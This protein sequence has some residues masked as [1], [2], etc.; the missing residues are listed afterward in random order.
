MFAI[1]FFKL[2]YVF[3]VF[4]MLGEN[5]TVP[6]R[7]LVCFQQ[8]RA[9]WVVL[10]DLQVPGTCELTNGCLGDGLP[11]PA[12]THRGAAGTLPSY[13]SSHHSHAVQSTHAAHTFL[14]LFFLFLTSFP[15]ALQ[16]LGQLPL[17]T[18]INIISKNV[19]LLPTAGQGGSR[20]GTGI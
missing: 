14:L 1:Q 3:N 7:N 6:S 13:P 17:K 2:F 4:L 9:V 11:A 5:G 15:N 16:R 20:R 18:G 19:N 8:S 10:D 12:P